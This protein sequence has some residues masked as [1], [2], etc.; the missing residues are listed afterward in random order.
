[1]P[2]TAKIYTRVSIGPMMQVIRLR[3]R[4]PALKPEM[5][6]IRSKQKAEL[7]ESDLKHAGFG[8]KSRAVV[9]IRMSTPPDANP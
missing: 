5:W 9:R 7:W 2:S 3:S 4:A 8:T 6:E 1:M